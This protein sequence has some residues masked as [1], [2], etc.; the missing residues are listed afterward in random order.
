MRYVIYALN[1]HVL[2]LLGI[3]LASALGAMPARA[4]SLLIMTVENVAVSPGS[5]GSFD[6]LLANDSTATSSITI[7]GFSVDVVV[8]GG[9]GVTF[10]GLDD[11]TTSATYIFDGNSLGFSSTV[12]GTELLG[13]DFAAV[14]GTILDPGGPAFGL[15]HITFS[16]DAGTLPGSIPVSLID[17][18]AGTSVSDTAAQNLDFTIN[19]G[20]I[21]VQGSPAVPEPTS[22]VMASAA[23][24]IG[25]ASAAC[26][27]RARR[28]S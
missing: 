15:A 22:F 17:Y 25:L 10:T 21:S 4:N 11:L 9:S 12:T 2:I 27:A 26:R 13:N 16:V 5:T 8:P 14:D 28:R 3:V 7:A 6:I 24:V 18:Q 19:N 1:S 20:I 23:V